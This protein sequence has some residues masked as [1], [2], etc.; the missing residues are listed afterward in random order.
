[1]SILQV[2]KY[3]VIPELAHVTRLTRFRPGFKR[4]TF[5]SSRVSLCS[6]KW[7]WEKGRRTVD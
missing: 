6:L 5:L 7:R 2:R 3:R 1:M 4:E